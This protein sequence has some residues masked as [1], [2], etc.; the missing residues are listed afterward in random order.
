MGFDPGVTS[1]SRNLCDLRKRWFTLVCSPVSEDH[2]CFQWMIGLVPEPPAVPIVLSR[3][4]QVTSSILE[5]LMDAQD[6][7]I[8]IV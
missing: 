7:P 8:C 1:L 4:A 2:E 5:R 3:Y 6:L